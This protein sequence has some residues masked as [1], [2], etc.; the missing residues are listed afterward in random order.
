MEVL[1][2][3]KAKQAQRQAQAQQNVNAPVQNA[4]VPVQNVQQPQQPEAPANA[5]ENKAPHR[6]MD[7]REIQGML[8][9]DKQEPARRNSVREPAKRPEIEKPKNDKKEVL[10]NN[11]ALQPKKK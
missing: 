11:K 6:K 7:A 1:D 2:E 5:P 3:Y 10:D 8:K 9:G 4:N